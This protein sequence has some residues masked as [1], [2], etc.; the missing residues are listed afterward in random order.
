M[1]RRGIWALILFGLILPSCG[2][3]SAEPAATTGTTTDVAAVTTTTTSTTPTTTTSTSTTTTS[4]TTTTLPPEPGAE[5]CLVVREGSGGGDC[6]GGPGILTMAFA[7]WLLQLPIENCP[8]AALADDSAR[9]QW[10][11]G[12]PTSVPSVLVDAVNTDG[13]TWGVSAGV[14]RAG[15]DTLE[16]RFEFRA[17]APGEKPY[18]IGKD[19]VATYEGNT[20]TFVSTF[21]NLVIGEPRNPEAVITITCDS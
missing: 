17:I 7:D 21:E 10:G 11:I 2:G 20:A 8:V 9:V 19:A 3:D 18:Y 14:G 5:R 13:E 12:S 15:Q 6:N 1:G 4:T 16:E